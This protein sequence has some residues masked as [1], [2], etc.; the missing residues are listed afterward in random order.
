MGV[1]VE[2][3]TWM[4]ACYLRFTA[5]PTIFT[6]ESQLTG[7]VMA[8]VDLL[9]ERSVPHNLIIADGRTVYLILRG[10]ASQ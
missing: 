7:L 10:F 8:V 2:H 6:Q 5:G 9:L 1:R 4:S 3:F